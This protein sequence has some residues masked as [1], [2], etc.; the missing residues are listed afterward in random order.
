MEGENSFA[1]RLYMTFCLYIFPLVGVAVHGFLVDADMLTLWS[2]GV[3]MVILSGLLSVFFRLNGNLFLKK[4]MHPCFF[5]TSFGISCVLLGAI[6]TSYVGVLWMFCVVYACMDA[7]VGLG[8]C[9]Y[10]Y[11]MF[12]YALFRV[13]EHRDMYPVLIWIIYGG[14]LTLM[15]ANYKQKRETIYLFIIL[16]TIYF[17]LQVIYYRFSI[18]ALEANLFSMIPGMVGILF[19]VLF[20]YVKVSARQKKGQADLE[21]QS[22]EETFS[23]E[24]ALASSYALYRLLDKHSQELLHHSKRVAEL[25]A[26]AI[27]LIGG[28]ELLV[29]TGGLYHEIGRITD[30]DNYIQAGLL[31]GEEMKFPKPL[32]DMIRQHSASF[33]IPESKEAAVLMLSDCIL[34]TSDILEKK[35]NRENYSEQQLVHSVFQNRLK[36]GHLKKSTLTQEQIQVLEQFYI[37]HAFMEENE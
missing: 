1:S 22:S 9:V 16:E 27:R 25:S 32:L 3:G 15:F 17:S 19:F 14:F 8:A 21:K 18:P 23:Y 31:L 20:G 37:H 2:E 7:D 4:I 24:K 35:G 10:G 11:L 12:A 29:R 6:D 30:N 13:F 36:K 26:G 33:S 5:W 34:M 28:D